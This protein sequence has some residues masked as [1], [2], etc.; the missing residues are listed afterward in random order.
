MELMF[1]EALTLFLD[2]LKNKGKSETTIKNYKADLGRFRDW[3]NDR[4]DDPTGRGPGVSGVGRIVL[5][6]YAQHL[7]MSG[8]VKPTTVNRRIISLKSF[9]K[10]LH[11]TNRIP[12]NPATDIKVKRIQRQNETR[13]LTRNEV[14]KLFHAIDTAQHQ[15]KLKK[16]R[17]KAIITVL[18][19]CGLRVSE[20]CNLRIDDIDFKAGLIT[21]QDGKGSKYRKVPF[22][23]A[24]KKAILNYLDERNSKSEFIFVSKR[25]EQMTTRGVQHLL[26][27]LSELTGLEVTPH[28][29]R[30]TFAKQV[31]DKTG[32]LEVVAD[33]C[34]H[35]DV[36]TSRRYVTPSMKELKN[37]V[38]EIEFEG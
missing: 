25:A 35:A 16:A 20:L 13:W 24:T 38:K 11:D 15:G 8:E 37:S 23:N 12:T 3:L 7:K 10:Y 5:K 19:N 21:V 4:E 30:H 33:L 29:L 31:A 32:K 6:E 27:R 17:D 14:G 34:G 36:N 2:D 22:G 9:F 18:V 28:M 1:D 26:Q